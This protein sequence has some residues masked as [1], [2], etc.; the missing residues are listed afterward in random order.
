MT[1]TTRRTSKSRGNIR[2]RR[3]HPSRLIR[4]SGRVQ[5]FVGIAFL[6]LDGFLEVFVSKPFIPNKINAT[7][8]KRTNTRQITA[9]IY[10]QA[11]IV[12]KRAYIG[13]LRVTS[14]RN[15]RDNIISTIVRVFLFKTEILPVF[16]NKAVWYKKENQSR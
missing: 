3:K 10:R 9:R 4:R 8:W 15:G 12:P 11:K 5:Y 7:E 14:N 16:P 1:F 13:I 6:N 2:T